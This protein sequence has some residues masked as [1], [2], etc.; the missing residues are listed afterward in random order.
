MKTKSDRT[1]Q[2]L[3]SLIQLCREISAGKYGH[4]Q[5]LFELTKEG[6]Y[7]PL[8]SQLAESFG[9]MM[10]QVESRE[11]GLE[12]TIEK[13]KL[14]EADLA[15]AKERL[16]HENIRLKQTLRNHFSP[17]RIIGKSPQISE[18]IRKVEKVADTPV[19]IL[20]TGETGTGKELIAKTVHYNSGRSEKPFVALN[21]SAIPETIFESEIFGIEKGVATG[22]MMRIGKIEQANGGTLFFDEI[23]DM[24]LSSQAKILRVIE[25]RLIDKVGGRK[26][27][28]VDIRIVAATNRDLK[29][30]V[31]KGTFREDLFYRL[32]V[33]HLQVPPLRERK[34]DIA[35][36]AKFFLD[37]SVKKLG[38]PPMRLSPEALRL[39]ENYRWPGN[40]REL[41]NEM[42][43]AVALAMEE[44]I[45]P[46]DLSEGL[47]EG[48]AGET[49]QEK[50]SV[51]DA[52]R[53]LIEKTLQNVK[54]NKSEAAR[55]LGMSR[56]GLRKKLARYGL[57]G[58]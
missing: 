55:L 40:I 3:L 35:I 4:A 33:I 29:E 6:T 45:C 14:A 44:T 54:G 43:R 47:H 39:L 50:V 41:E 56:E 31:R 46:A 38:C 22:V 2:L 8:V 51:K 27:T 10:V 17:I 21:C 36:L 9:M 24:P 34:G 30:A 13:L 48:S 49:P 25:D 11:Y 19:N 15:R 32:N 53:Q 5:E 23:G 16:A 52:E 42:E 7:P 57:D 18:L 12:G 20:I 26:S 37:Q 1:D 28:P 58:R